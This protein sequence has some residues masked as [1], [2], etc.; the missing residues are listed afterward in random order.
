MLA[1]TTVDS[2]KLATGRGWRLVRSRKDPDDVKEG[3]CLVIVPD[4]EDPP[5]TELEEEEL[6]VWDLRMMRKHEIVPGKWRV[7]LNGPG[8][9]GGQPDT[10]RAIHA[11][12]IR[13]GEGDN[14]SKVTVNPV[15]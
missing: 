4:Q 5:L 3:D 10:R 7:I 14:P 8:A 15:D 11:L 1:G 2:G 6:L 9:R 13:Y 12:G